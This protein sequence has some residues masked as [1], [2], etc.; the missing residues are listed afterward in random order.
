ALRLGHARRAH[1][2]LDALADH[3]ELP[4]E[5]LLVLHGLAGTDED[6]PHDR[7]DLL[8]DLAGRLLL[9]RHL[10]PAEDLLALLADHLLDDALALVALVHLGREEDHADRV[11]AGR[12]QLD[13]QRL[14]LAT[15]EVVRDLEEDARAVAG[16]RIAATRAAMREVLEDGEPLLDDRV[17]ARAL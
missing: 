3:V 13:A 11:L 14:R 10:P 7:H 5:R 1:E 2:V 12:R 6:L 4:L 15:E 16:E 17:R 9:D 8:R